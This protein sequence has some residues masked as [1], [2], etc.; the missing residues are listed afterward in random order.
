MQQQED[1]DYHAL[2]KLRFCM[3]CMPVSCLQDVVD[4][5]ASG[6]TPIFK[7]PYTKNLKRH[8]LFVHNIY[9]E[10]SSNNTNLKI[11]EGLVIIQKPMGYPC[12]ICS[13]QSIGYIEYIKHVFCRHNQEKNE[14]PTS[15]L[16]KKICSLCGKR[17]K[18]E[19]SL[20][21]HLLITIHKNKMTGQ[22]VA[23]LTILTK[24]EE[25]SVAH[26]KSINK[27]NITYI[28]GHTSDASEYDF[29]MILASFENKKK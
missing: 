29:Q 18:S 15:F 4:K 6:S 16:N 27:G 1:F 24:K 10:W 23:P 26:Q 5:Y 13:A 19:L 14:V 11:R 25:K 20:K 22:L 17:Y 8:M 3:L 28:L 21:N 12:H 9:N 2:P 7:D